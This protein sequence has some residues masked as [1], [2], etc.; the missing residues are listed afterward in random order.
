M[1]ITRGDCQ[2]CQSNPDD[3][4][5]VNAFVLRTPAMYPDPSAFLERMYLTKDY[6][7]VRNFLWYDNPE[8]TDLTSQG[9]EVPDREEAMDLYWDATLKIIEDVPD[10]FVDQ[11]HMISPMRQYVQGYTPHALMSWEWIYYSI[12]KE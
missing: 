12:Y 11:F 4:M 5:F 10:I 7:G 8:V 3:P 6:G 9:M 2:E 1:T